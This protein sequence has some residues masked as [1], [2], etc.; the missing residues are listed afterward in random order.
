MMV[1]GTRSRTVIHIDPEKLECSNPCEIR[2]PDLR[3]KKLAG[4]VGDESGNGLGQF[5]A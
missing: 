2:L 3:C 4:C 5:L 1:C